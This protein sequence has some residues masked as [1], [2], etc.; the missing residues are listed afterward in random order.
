MGEQLPKHW[1]LYGDAALGLRL[2]HRGSPD[3]ELRS[4]QNLDPESLRQSVPF[5]R[6]AV[7]VGRPNHAKFAVGGPTPCVMTFT[8]GETMAQIHPPERASNGLAVA[9]L[10]DLAGEKMFRISKDPTAMDFRDVGVLLHEG[11]SVN[12]MIGFA[13]AQYRDN[14]E[15]SAAV[16]SLTDADRRGLN[17][18]NET[19]SMLIKEGAAGRLP[20]RTPIHSER[21]TTDIQQPAQKPRFADHFERAVDPYDL[22]DPFD[23]Q[24]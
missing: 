21:I 20:P 23:R 2:G 9:S 15:P 13:K 6:D 11:A 3:F 18:G 10:S 12:E 14:F 19:E 1:V 4:S 5:L 22:R 17:L 8:G 16:F 24:R 7:M